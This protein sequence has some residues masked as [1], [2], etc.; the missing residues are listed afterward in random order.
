MRFDHVLTRVLPP[1][2]DRLEKILYGLSAS[3]HQFWLADLNDLLTPM[4]PLEL[5][6][7]VEEVNVDRLSSLLQNYVTAML[8][9]AANR[10]GIAPPR[11]AGRGP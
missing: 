7:A 5:F 3:D 2:R 4:A 10:T 9:L 8:K 11:W 1:A 6:E